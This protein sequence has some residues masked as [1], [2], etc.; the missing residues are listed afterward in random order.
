SD[1]ALESLAGLFAMELITIHHE[2]L[3]SAHKQWYS[4]LLIAEALKKVLGF[5][6]EKKVIDTSLTLKVIH[7]LAKVLS[8][9][10]AKGLID[11]RMTP[12]GH[13]VTA[14]YRKK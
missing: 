10:L 7:G 1:K 3:D 13:S 6:S 11:K 12:Y 5:K 14:V 9:L 4:F 8:P 2:E